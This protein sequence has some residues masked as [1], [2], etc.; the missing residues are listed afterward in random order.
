MWV[1]ET[2]LRLLGLVAMLLPY[3]I[4]STIYLSRFT[5]GSLTGL[6]PSKWA[7][8]AGQRAPCPYLISSEFKA[9]AT[10][11][12]VCVWWDGCLELH[13]GLSCLHG[14]NFTFMFLSEISV[15]DIGNK[16]CVLKFPQ[17]TR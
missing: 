2:R 5:V 17:W 12:E 10:T 9:C 7:G 8:L 13:L 14:K 4:G 6:K 16:F 15:L 11:A 1:L 3:F